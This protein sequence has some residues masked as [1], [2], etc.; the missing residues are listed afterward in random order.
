MHTPRH[1]VN[2]FAVNVKY[3]DEGKKYTKTLA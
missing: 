3:V 2:Y 1:H